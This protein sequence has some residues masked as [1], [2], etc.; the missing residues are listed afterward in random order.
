MVNTDKKY[1][2][3]GLVLNIESKSIKFSCIIIYKKYFK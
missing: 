3:F 1:L 2:Y